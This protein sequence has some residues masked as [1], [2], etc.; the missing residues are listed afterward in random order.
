MTSLRQAM[1]NIVTDIRRSRLRDADAERGRMQDKV[2]DRQLALKRSLQNRQEKRDRIYEEERLRALES[3][4][5]SAAHTVKAEVVNEPVHGNGHDLM[6][7]LVQDSM[8]RRARNRAELQKRKEP[9]REASVG[10]DSGCSKDAN[11][12]EPSCESLGSSSKS[13]SSSSSTGNIG[14]EDD[15]HPAAAGSGAET[16]LPMQHD[17]PETPSPRRDWQ[18][19]PQAE[20]PWQP[21]AQVPAWPWSGAQPW[22]HA[23]QWSIAQPW[24]WQQGPPAGQMGQHMAPW[25]QQ[26]QPPQQLQS[27]PSQPQPQWQQSSQPR[28]K[29]MEARCFKEQRKEREERSARMVG[30]EKAKQLRNARRQ[31]LRKRQALQGQGRRAVR[32]AKNA[33]QEPQYQ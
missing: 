15:C 11:R 23:T 17:V 8:S 31:E 27:V 29:Q 30:S 22:H 3:V 21:K 10:I 9:K 6:E 7:E 16:P 24:G 28:P 26:R 4:K 1:T 19:E 32:A 18:P 25:A 2:V 13:S 20:P 12:A 14:S 5:N 33:P